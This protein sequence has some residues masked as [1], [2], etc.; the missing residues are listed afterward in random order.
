MKCFIHREMSYRV[1]YGLSILLP[2]AG[3]VRAFRNKLNMSHIAAV[4]QEHLRTRLI[5]NL[6]E[7]SYKGIPSV[8]KTTGREVALDSI[9][10]KRAF[11]RIFQAI[12]KADPDQGPLKLSNMDV[13]ATYH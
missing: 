4:P 10:F 2:E 13:I 9:K 12:L 6:S 5:I 1:Q 7:N 8:N 11:P 3:M